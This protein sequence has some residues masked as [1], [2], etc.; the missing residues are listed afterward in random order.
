MNSAHTVLILCLTSLM[1]VHASP[2]ELAATNLPGTRS[3]SA[4]R[5]M[6]ESDR[7]A[8]EARI[9]QASLVVIVEVDLG[10]Y[11]EPRH[12]RTAVI[13]TLL[14]AEIEEGRESTLLVVPYSS[15]H[16]AS[17]LRWHSGS[18]WLELEPVHRAED[19]DLVALRPK[20]GSTPWEGSSALQLADELPA[21]Q[22]WWT[23]GP[24][25]VPE[26]H[27][28]TEERPILWYPSRR[29]RSWLEE[30]AEGPTL[31]MQAHDPR[32]HRRFAYFLRS[33]FPMLDRGYP[34]VDSEGALVGITART[35]TDTGAASG[36]IS[37]A[38]FETWLERLASQDGD[39]TWYPTIREESVDVRTG[40]D[41]IQ[42]PR[43][44]R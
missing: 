20:E 16:G 8:L 1:L 26:E 9:E 38:H 21:N 39:G 13:G 31:L 12:V 43:S 30:Q 19:L 24:I 11:R 28:Q 5:P 29:Q 7:A 25:D 37:F 34:L 2:S 40:R 41:A 27:L 35:P 14:R 15:V 42:P 10:P 32:A 17:S 36:V 4:F 6:S 3:V 44:R 23:R 22:I 33:P 18:D